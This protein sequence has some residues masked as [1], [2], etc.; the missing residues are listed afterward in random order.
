MAVRQLVS[1]LPPCSPWRSLARLELDSHLPRFPRRGGE[2]SSRKIGA[3]SLEV[4]CARRAGYE[5]PPET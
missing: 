5:C 1:H 4:G 2:N 3:E